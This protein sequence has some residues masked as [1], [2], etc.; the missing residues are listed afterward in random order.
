MLT[1]SDVRDDL[2]FITVNPAV[3]NPRLAGV[4]MAGT[5]RYFWQPEK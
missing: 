2:N 5:V 3:E 4:D 1:C